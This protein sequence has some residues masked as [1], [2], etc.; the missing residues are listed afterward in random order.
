[1]SMVTSRVGRALG[2]L[3]GSVSLGLLLASAGCGSGGPKPIPVT[4]TVTRDGKAVEGAT[5]TL[6]PQF[7]G[8]PAMGTTDKDGK[9]TL[10]THPL[11]DGALPGKHLVS[12]RKVIISGYQ[13]DKDGLSGP[14]VPGGPKEQWLIPKKY[15]DA[16]AWGHTVEVKPGMEPLKLE[17]TS[18]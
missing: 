17:L 14:P 7:Q 11:G 6:L 15:S 5:V 4:G 12:V 13:A 10:K 2:S 3:L 8:Q 1:M 18:H 9:F 16:K